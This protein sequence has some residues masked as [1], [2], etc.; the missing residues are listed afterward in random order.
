[1]EFLSG[2]NDR[3]ASSLTK[4]LYI[5]LKINSSP[6]IKFNI[7]IKHFTG[8]LAILK[9]PPKYNHRMAIYSS[10][11]IFPRSDIYSIRN[12]HLISLI[13]CIV[14][15]KLTCTFSNLSF[16]IVLET[17]AETE[18]FVFEWAWCVL[19]S[20][21]Y[22]FLID[23]INLLPFRWNI[24]DLTWLKSFKFQSWNIFDYIMIH[25]TNQVCESINFC[26]CCTFSW[27]GCPNC[28]IKFFYCDMEA[29][30][31]LHLLNVNLKSSTQFLDKFISW[32]I[33][34]WLC[35]E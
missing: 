19:W 32:D 6:V 13:N 5:L 12:H 7:I 31:F 34:W 28:Q 2:K 15:R 25:S 9:K 26:N 35:N 30:S 1:M 27:R 4:R 3:A 24:F 22:F 20:P 11:M 21:Q 8:Q 29:V 10:M 33:I 16:C 14:D 17:S 23:I 18:D